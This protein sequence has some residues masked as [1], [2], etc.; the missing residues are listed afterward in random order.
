MYLVTSPLSGLE[1]QNGAV[2]LARAEHSKLAAA[3]DALCGGM[4][5]V[6]ILL[7]GSYVYDVAGKNY[8]YE[9]KDWD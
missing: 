5:R 7:L 9:S 8:I 1:S 3:L 4:V 6:D 2:A